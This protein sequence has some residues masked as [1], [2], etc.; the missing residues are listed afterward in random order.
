MGDPV[1]E[2]AQGE[3]GGELADPADSAR[4]VG[5]GGVGVQRAE[6]PGEPDRAR[7][8]V[9]DPGGGGVGVGVRRVQGH[10]GPDQSVRDTP[11]GGVRGH[12]R[13]AAQ[14]QRM[15]GDDQVRVPGEGL[16]DDGVHGVH[17]EQDPPYRLLRVSADQADRVPGG[18][19]P[20]GVDLLEGRGDV[21]QGD[22]GRGRG[23]H[24]HETN[25]LPCRA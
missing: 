20:E 12:A 6:R 15:V 22:G 4:P 19:P 7:Q 1:G 2:V 5:V 21:G 10:P 14:H 23:V 25:A 9:R 17:G 13:D 18:G 8:G 24:G 16:V 11:L 3:R